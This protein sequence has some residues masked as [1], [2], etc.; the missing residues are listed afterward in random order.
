MASFIDFEVSVDDEDMDKDN[1]VSDDSDAE[2]LLSFIDDNVKINDA[3]CCWSFV[4]VE[5]D[6][7]EILAKEY[8]KGLQEIYKL[9]DISNLCET[10]EEENEVDDF[11][12]SEQIVDKFKKTLFPKTEETKNLIHL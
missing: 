9:D 5:T 10:S 4:N 8:E 1:E 7:D 12:N 11:K 3:N 6:I 2:S